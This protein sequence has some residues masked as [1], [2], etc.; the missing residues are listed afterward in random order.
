MQTYVR[1]QNYSAGGGG[2]GI[3]KGLPSGRKRS[4]MGRKKNDKKVPIL[5][6]KLPY[7]KECFF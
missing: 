3:K 7:N 2:G 4:P 5:R 1:T 6:K